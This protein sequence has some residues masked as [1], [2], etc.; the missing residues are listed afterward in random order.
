MIS[1]RESV[2]NL[3]MGIPKHNGLRD[4]VQLLWSGSALNNYGYNSPSDIGPGNNQFIYSLYSTKSRHRPAVRNG[5]TG[6][7][8]QRLHEQRPDHLAAAYRHR[9]SAIPLRARSWAAARRTSA[10]PTPS[11]TTCR[12]ARRSRRVAERIKAP[13]AYYVPD[14]PHTP[15]TGRFRSTITRSTSIRTTRGITKVQYTYAL[16][17]S[18]YLRAYGYTFYSDW[19]HTDPIFGA[20]G[21]MRRRSRPSAQ[22][23]LITHTAGGAL[24]FQD[25]LNDQNLLSLNGN[26]T[27]AGVIRFNNSSAILRA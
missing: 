18:A 22:Y 8:R 16:S 10:T 23:Q 21:R 6:F 11:R 3:H 25:Q 19:M 24:D 4:D 15:S 7:D 20:P 9:A 27:T 13:G 5:R 12:S 17:Q 14:T 26:Y 1:D 2:V